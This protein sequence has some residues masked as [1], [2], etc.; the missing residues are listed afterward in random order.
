MNRPISL[1]EILQAKIVSLEETAG[2]LKGL[3]ELKQSVAE[4]EEYPPHNAEGLREKAREH[5][6]HAI[7]VLVAKGTLEV[8]LGARTKE[9]Q[10]NLM[11]HYVLEFGQ[12]M[13]RNARLSN[14]LP[15]DDP[16]KEEV[17]S[18]GCQASFVV[19]TLNGILSDVVPE[20]PY[21]STGATAHPT[22]AGRLGQVLS[23]TANLIAV[24]IGGV[25]LVLASYDNQNAG[26]ILMVGAV[27]AALVWMAG[28]A[29]RY[30]LAGS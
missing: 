24:A 2:Q 17:D 28:R 22:M 21:L 7:G 29:L 13:S 23:W 20:P 27:L 18:E 4:D 15:D 9:E 5:K 26:V 8:I 10:I 11:R 16:R 12:A 6:R 14:S 25:F 19:S 30:V 1:R 3:S